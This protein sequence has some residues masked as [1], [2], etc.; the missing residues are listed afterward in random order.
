MNRKEALSLL[1]ELLAY[2]NSVQ[3]SQIVAVSEIKELDGWELKVKWTPK[4]S[5]KAYITCIAAQ[6]GLSVTKI[7][8]YTVFQ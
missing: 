6:R 5:E 3:E 1:K 2:C 8:G 7:D 4:S